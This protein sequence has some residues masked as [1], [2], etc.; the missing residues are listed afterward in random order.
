MRCG[1]SRSRACSRVD[2]MGAHALLAAGKQVDRQQPLM[3]RDMGALEKCSDHCGKRLGAVTALVDAWARALPLQFC[4]VVDRT[5]VR[6]HRTIRPARCLEVSAG[7]FFV[8]VDWVR[9]VGHSG[10]PLLP[11]ILPIW[12]GTSGA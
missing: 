3:Q 8:V 4:G 5:A 2:L 12:A 10:L 7:G 6:A 11:A 9:K 1:R